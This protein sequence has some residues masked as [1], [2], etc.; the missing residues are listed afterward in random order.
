MTTQ[1]NVPRQPQTQPPPAELF[2]ETS[3]GADRR[4]GLVLRVLSGPDQGRQLVIERV[5]NSIGRGEDQELQLTDHQVS[6]RHCELSLVGGVVQLR[7]TESRNG[8]F[9]NEVRVFEAWIEPGARF[10]VGDTQLALDVAALDERQP[11]PEHFGDLV[12]TSRA[13]R[14]SFEALACVAPTQLTCLLQGET[15]TGKELAARA[16]HAQSQYK[17]GPFVVIDCGAISESLIEDK[18]FGHERGSFTGA[19]KDARGAFEEAHGGSVFLD[20]VGE[21]PLSFQP[22]L[23]RVLERR[24]IVRLGSHRAINVDVRVIAATH[25]DLPAMVEAGHFRQDLYYRLCEASIWLPPLRARLDDIE[26]LARYLL[27]QDWCGP[28]RVEPDAVTYLRRHA[29]SGNVRE[30]RNVLRRA[31]ALAGEGGRITAELL[32]RVITPVLTLRPAPPSGVSSAPPSSPENSGF[33]SLDTEITHVNARADLQIAEAT[34]AYRKQYVHHL[35]KQY[36]EDCDAIAR[37]MGVHVKYAR[38]L[39][40]RYGLLGSG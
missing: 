10:R 25:R 13:M 38:R 19:V 8:T 20:E 40:R 37:H 9:V 14:E 16:L 5:K 32:M 29:W 21:L 17:D 15:G 31:R 12:G 28:V 23:L 35:H 36:G 2:V 27:A 39:M 30:M 4:P 7:D 18:L 34:D 26:V 22:K 24:E 33:P 3:P 6:R 11:M 1:R